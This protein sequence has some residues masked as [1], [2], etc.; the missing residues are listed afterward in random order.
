MWAALQAPLDRFLL[1][2]LPMPCRSHAESLPSH[3]VSIRVSAPVSA[4]NQATLS[5]NSWSGI[6]AGGNCTP[7]T[8]AGLQF[9]SPPPPFPPFPPRP[10]SPPPPTVAFVSARL[11]LQNVTRWN[12]VQKRIAENSIAIALSMGFPGP[13]VSP[14]LVNVTADAFTVRR[15]YKS[16]VKGPL[17]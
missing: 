5:A 1:F 8:G 12:P 7:I 11:Q 10:S 3:P 17:L 9:Y 6:V 16:D 14:R 2:M 15:R 13:A 4:A